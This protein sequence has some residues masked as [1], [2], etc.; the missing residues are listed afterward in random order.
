MG[1]KSASLNATSCTAFFSWPTEQKA[2]CLFSVSVSHFRAKKRRNPLKPTGDR[3]Y[4]TVFRK[5]TST[6]LLPLAMLKWRQSIDSSSM[7]L[8]TFRGKKRFIWHTRKLKSAWT[9][10]NERL[11]FQVTTNGRAQQRTLY[12]NTCNEQSFPIVLIES[13]F[14]VQL[15]TI[16]LLRNSVCMVSECQQ[17]NSP[18]WRRISS[19]FLISLCSIDRTV[20]CKQQLF[21]HE[22]SFLNSPTVEEK[23]WWLKSLLNKINDGYVKDQGL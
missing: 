7:T 18:I 14:E 20:N 1:T 12:S 16:L 4:V 11:L 6:E 22:N 23:Q 19:L 9:D 21:S 10:L 5:E 3:V 2:F 17:V 13:S 8:P 15:W